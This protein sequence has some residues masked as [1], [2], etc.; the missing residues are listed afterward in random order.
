MTTTPTAPQFTVLAD[1]GQGSY[2]VQ[3]DPCPYCGA[4]MTIVRDRAAGEFTL[5]HDGRTLALDG[6]TGYPTDPHAAGTRDQVNLIKVTL[7]MGYLALKA[8]GCDYD[9]R[10]DLAD[11]HMTPGDW[12]RSREAVRELADA[13]AQHAAQGDDLVFEIGWSGPAAANPRERA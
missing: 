11:A 6:A 13:L 1:D 12:M 9:L 2:T 8:F 10:T 4:A 5:C 3:C 7:F